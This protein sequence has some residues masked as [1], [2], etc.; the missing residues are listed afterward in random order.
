LRCLNLGTAPAL[1]ATA[2]SGAR[3]G[4]RW[5]FKAV[6]GGDRAATQNALFLGLGVLLLLRFRAVFDQPLRRGRNGAPDQPGS[7]RGA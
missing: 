2:K 6:R 4:F 3:G 1:G 7:G 5:R